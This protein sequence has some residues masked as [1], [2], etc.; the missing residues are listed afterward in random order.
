MADYFWS[1]IPGKFLDKTNG[2]IAARP[3]TG[4]VREWYEMLIDVMIDV[5][6]M[7]LHENAG[8]PMSGVSWRAD[9]KVVLIVHASVLFKPDIGKEQVGTIGHETS[10]VI[11]NLP[12]RSELSLY[13]TGWLELVQW[14]GSPAERVI[15]SVSVKDIRI[16]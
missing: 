13:D 9:A 8:K 4:T 1:R 5:T 12:I 11:C 15:G 10:G 7:A 14:E 2:T 16:N 6:G 3:F